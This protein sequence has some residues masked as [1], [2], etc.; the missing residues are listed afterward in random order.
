MKLWLILYVGSGVGGTWGPLPY[1]M[2]EC[3]RRADVMQAESDLIRDTGKNQ[4]GETIPEFN[5]KQ[6]GTFRFVCEER[7]TRPELSAE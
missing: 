6:I 7:E 5:R 2:A 4:K 1:D 3:Q